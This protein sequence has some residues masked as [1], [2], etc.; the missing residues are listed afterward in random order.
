VRS[1]AASLAY[2][3]PHD[4]AEHA[5]AGAVQI[6]FVASEAEAVATQDPELHPDGVATVFQTRQRDAL[7]AWQAGDYARASSLQ[8]SNTS[9]L[10]SAH[11]AAPTPMAA[12]RLS[13]EVAEAEAAAAD[14]AAPNTTPAAQARARGR[15]A[16]LRGSAESW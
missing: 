3:T 10:R 14:L 2:R 1:I 9:A 16:A 8:A 6:A 4:A 13:V 7:A 12:A 11:A 15:S 5:A